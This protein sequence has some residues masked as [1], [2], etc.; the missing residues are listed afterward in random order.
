MVK[1][2]GENYSIYIADYQQLFSSYTVRIF[3]LRPETP[4]D[5]VLLERVLSDSQPE[6]QP[7]NHENQPKVREGGKFV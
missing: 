1:L 3:M 4:G 5:K 6:T 7:D 2:F